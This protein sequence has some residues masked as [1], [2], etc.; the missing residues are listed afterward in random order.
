MSSYNHLRITDYAQ[1]LL[2]DLDQLDGW[3]ERVKA[4]Q[5]NWIGRS[6]GAEI[7]FVLA[8]VDGVTPTDTKITVFT[9][10]ADTIYGCTFMLLPPESSLATELVVGT[11][12]EAAFANLKETATKVTSIERQGTDREKHGVFTGR[13]ALNPVTGESIPI[14]VSD[15]VL[16]DYG[17]GAVMG[18]PAGDS[19]KIPP[20][21]I[22]LQYLLIICI[23][24]MTVRYQYTLFNCAVKT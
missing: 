24:R 12:Y 19:I 23:S 17:T 20:L 15:Y 10:R 21:F 3:P 16:L 22:R 2:D 13:Y 1:E 5:A 4:M 7:D 6:E 8:D 9:T 14:W 11:E 18:V